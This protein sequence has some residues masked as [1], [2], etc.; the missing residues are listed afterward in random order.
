MRYDD[1]HR[2]AFRYV[3][4]PSHTLFH[5]SNSF[6]PSSDSKKSKMSGRKHFA[7]TSISSSDMWDLRMIL[8]SL[9]TY[10]LLILHKYHS[11]PSG[12]VPDLD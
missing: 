10:L 8:T 3:F 2:T 4:L 6:L 5:C 9:P 11:P 1:K 12:G 7:N